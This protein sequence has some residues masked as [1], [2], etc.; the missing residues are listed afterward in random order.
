MSCNCKKKII[1][2]NVNVKTIEKVK[3]EKFN[4]LKN[5]ID[6]LRKTIKELEKEIIN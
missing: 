3:D 4:E 2:T 5:S 6:L 1:N